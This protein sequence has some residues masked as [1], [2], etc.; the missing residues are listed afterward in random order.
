MAKKKTSERRSTSPP[1][2]SPQAGKRPA[3][4]TTYN[5]YI[6]IDFS[7]PHYSSDDDGRL[8]RWFRLTQLAFCKNVTALIPHIQLVLWPRLFVPSD[9]EAQVSR[10]A[11][12]HRGTF[13]IGIETWSVLKPALEKRYRR[14]LAKWLHG[15]AEWVQ[16]KGIWTDEK[17]PPTMEARVVAVD[18]LGA[19][20]E[21]QY[22]WPEKHARALFIG[23]GAVLFD[24]DEDEERRRLS[25][26]L[27]I[28][29][30]SGNDSLGVKFPAAF[31]VLQ[32]L[33]WD[34][35]Y[36]IDDY[37]V[38]YEDRFTGFH[39]VEAKEWSTESTA[40]TFIPQHR[41]RSFVRKS[42]REVVWNRARK[43]C[44]IFS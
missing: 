10:A 5:H 23:S 29:A 21:D 20:V 14:E 38:V 44:T 15:Y 27:P 24:E 39:E 37:V 36:R 2:S 33:R 41:I 13:L 11:T 17:V 34:E 1:A 35:A 12:Q 7:S 26:Y 25:E 6:R 9:E 22:M 31:D 3:F 4:L 16:R 42:T 43:S 8:L 28:S 30:S 19:L 32:R 18:T 40:D